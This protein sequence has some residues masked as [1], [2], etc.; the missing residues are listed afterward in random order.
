M[1]I[2]LT[3]G[4]RPD[5][6]G[7]P[8]GGRESYP[9]EVVDRL[10]A[11]A[12]T[13]IARYP[14]PR[15]A[16]L[17]LLHLVQ[18]ED[19]YLTPAGIAFC[20]EQFDLTDAEVAAVATFYSMYRAHRDRRVPGRRVHQHAVRDHGRRRHPARHWR[21][22][23]GWQRRADHRRRPDHP[24]AHRVQ[25][26][27]RLRPGGDGQL[28]VL[29]QPD[30]LERTGTGRRAAGRRSPSRPPAAPP[31]CSFREMAR[32]LAG[33]GDRTP[34]T[35]A[36][37]ERRPS[38]GLRVAQASGE[39]PAGRNGDDTMLTPVLSRFW[40][41]PEPWTLQTYLRHDGYQALRTA[42]AHEARRGHLD[43]QG[44]RAARPRRRG[45]PDRHEVV[46]HPAG[47]DRRGAKPKYLVINA[48]ESEPG[49]CKDIPLM[50]DHA[51]LPGRGRDH[52]GL[53]DPRPPRVHLRARRGGAGAAP[54]AGRGR[55]GLRG[56]AT[57]ARTS[58]ARAST[59][60]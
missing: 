1:T 48:D 10:A 37:P 16:L 30:P 57:W 27:L 19:G 12:A 54:A 26:G 46:V 5:E 60:T 53:R 31:L 42:L 47:R 22:T 17:P 4:P 15:S 51:A 44:V 25:R 55:R 41:E 49:T 29:R 39:D 20:A 52:R 43:G 34:S 36:D 8:I 24:R 11:D 35:S 3:L 40:D 18:S 21:A 59:S 9:A 38:P 13:I 2:E 58:S 28:G 23:S 33:V 56:R 32:T 7:P 50:F 45:L 14:Q 6:P